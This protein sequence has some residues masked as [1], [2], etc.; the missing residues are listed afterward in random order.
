MLVH[1]WLQH[2][3]PGAWG[4]SSP[5]ASAVVMVTQVTSSP[6][7]CLTRLGRAISQ[8]KPLI[9]PL[10]DVFTQ[11]VHSDLCSGAVGCSSHSSVVQ[12]LGWAPQVDTSG[13]HLAEGAGR[14]SQRPC[15]WRHVAARAA[16]PA[17]RQRCQRGQRLHLW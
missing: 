8:S 12:D 1:L 15:S 5:G 16:P 11:T 4:P 3:H 13:G 6:Q 10:Q 17:R 14:A 9:L 2:L 7:P